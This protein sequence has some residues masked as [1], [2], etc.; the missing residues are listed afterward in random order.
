MTVVANCTVEVSFS[1]VV[2]SLAF[3]PLPSPPPGT[4]LH[5]QVVPDRFRLFGTYMLLFLIYVGLTEDAKRIRVP[6]TGFCPWVV[7]HVMFTS[8]VILN[9]RIYT[10]IYSSIEINAL[11]VRSAKL[12]QIFRGF[13]G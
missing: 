5:P 4:H 1:I 11:H 8:N 9:P 13:T 12:S 6:E 3:Q 2:E 10:N 7:L